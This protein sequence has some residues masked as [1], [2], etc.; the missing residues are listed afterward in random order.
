MEAEYRNCEPFLIDDGQLD[1][2]TPQQCFVLGYELHTVV[3]VAE[4]CDHEVDMT[5]HA[6]NVER[7]E[8]F[9]TARHRGWSW[10]WPSDDVSESWVY[11]KIHP[12]D[13]AAL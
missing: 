1:G 4:C 8:A 12:R 6:E 13:M 2:M 9:L 5:V 10:M 7:V 3:K 11:L